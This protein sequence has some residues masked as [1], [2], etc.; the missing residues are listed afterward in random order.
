MIR[1]CKMC[2][3]KFGTNSSGQLYCNPC[4]AKRRTQ[5]KNQHYYCL[6]CGTELFRR[7]K[8]RGAIKFCSDLCAVL[9]K[10]KSREEML[11][12]KQIEV[13]ENVTI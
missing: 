5:K 3:E 2:G 12:K 7:D 10:I 9:Y 1:K 8:H 11:A 13:V 6:E 4:R